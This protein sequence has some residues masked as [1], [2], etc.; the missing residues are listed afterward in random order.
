MFK[1]GDKVRVVNYEGEDIN[2]NGLV[3]NIIH[4]AEP[5]WRVS[6]PNGAL[7]SFLLLKDSELELVDSSHYV[8]NEICEEYD[9]LFFETNGFRSNTWLCSEDGKYYSRL[10]A[11]EMVFKPRS[12]TANINKMK[13]KN[14]MD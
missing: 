11:H 4:Q 6:F 8:K 9:S 5:Y 3:G 13:K 12:M 7:F 2:P 10:P 14:D 1:V